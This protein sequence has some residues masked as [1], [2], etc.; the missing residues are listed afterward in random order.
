MIYGFSFARCDVNNQLFFLEVYRLYRSVLILEER[1]GLLFFL[2]EYKTLN[3][4][5]ELFKVGFLAYFLESSVSG[6]VLRPW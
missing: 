1:R 5:K 4:W 6:G 2:D 3:L